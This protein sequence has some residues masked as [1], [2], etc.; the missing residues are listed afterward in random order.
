[1]TGLPSSKRP[2]IV[3]TLLDDD[4]G[5][6]VA[7]RPG[8]S[9]T[10][11]ALVV[12]VVLL[13]ALAGALSAAA[14]STGLQPARD[15]GCT[16]WHECRLMALAAAARGDYE[17]FHDLA[18]RAV[19][20]GPPKDPALMFL[21]A[22]AQALSGRPHDALIML[23]RLAEMGVPSDVATNDEFVRTR[24][25]PG[26]PEVSDLIERLTHPDSPADSSSAAVT[27]SP[28]AKIRTPA[29]PP[30]PTSSAPTPTSSAPTPTPS[31]T[32]ASPPSASPSS[33]ALSPSSSPALS[34]NIAR[35][36]TAGFT[37]GGLAYDAVSR[38]FLV[39]DRLGR[40]LMIVADGADHAVDFV[41]AAS[42]GFRDITA[43][44]IDDRRGDLWVVSTETPAEGAG[45]L[46]K[47]Q[48]VSG[49]LLKS[50]PIAAGADPVTIVDLAVTPAGVVLVL[51]SAGGRLLTLHPGGT[52]VEP[53]MKIG[54]VEPVSVA[55]ASDP[56]IV[57]VA[58]RDGISR[59]DL[60]ARTATRVTAPASI[61]LA[62]VAQIRWR[63][64]A[65]FAIRGEPDGTHQVIRLDLNANGRA[66]TR[67]TILE[68]PVPLAGQTFVAISGD[69]LVYMVD[70]SKDAV[71]RTHHDGPG[72][73]D[74]VAYRVPLR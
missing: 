9:V 36:S 64:H 58:H 6:H 16:E 74:F 44:E 14:P 2:Q 54:A 7:T 52:A 50:F 10:T 1:M 56:G 20:T 15:F 46:H 13:V 70:Q 30:P 17:T 39:G 42:A 19:Q 21:L 18:W 73:A 24:Q 53:D 71:G 37:L 68:G 60:R 41:R 43:I 4:V 57:Y 22:R 8:R 67:S 32:T 51:D 33:S 38:R 11:R 34:A 55:A 31:A 3:D 45:T 40:K 61:S 62:H 27:S 25:L 23:Q 65:L 69:E 63:R 72:T 29:V 5:S 35:F 48:L 12:P 59:I 66:V 26:W 47:L 49:R 28:P